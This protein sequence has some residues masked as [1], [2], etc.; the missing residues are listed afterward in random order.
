MFLVL[1]GTIGGVCGLSMMELKCFLFLFLVAHSE[2]GV[3]FL[4]CDGSAVSVRSFSGLILGEG[5]GLVGVDLVGF[6]QKCRMCVWVCYLVS[7]SIIF[8]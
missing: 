2:P 7:I 3:W 6:R 8:S 4:Q 5:V 1:F